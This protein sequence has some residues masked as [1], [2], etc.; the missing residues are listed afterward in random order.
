MAHSHQSPSPTR[1]HHRTL[2]SSRS[3]A[4]VSG[5][6]FGLLALAVT[7]MV[8]NVVL[9]RKL[10]Q[11]ETGGGVYSTGVRSTF[12]QVSTADDPSKM[13][14]QVTSLQKTIHDLQVE[15]EQ[16][17][18]SL[19]QYI[20]Q[21]FKEKEEHDNETRKRVALEKKFQRDNS[22]SEKEPEQDTANL[23]APKG[24]LAKKNDLAHSQ[25]N[26][27][28]RIRADAKVSSFAQALNHSTPL[29]DAIPLDYTTLPDPAG[30]SIKSSVDYHACCG[31]G[32]RLSRMSDANYVAQRLNLGLRSFWGFCGNLE[33]HYYL[34]GPQRENMLAN[35]TDTGNYLRISKSFGGML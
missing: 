31:L 29:P 35:V 13:A 21:L 6:K 24:E 15:N 7:A 16:M 9:I 12:F 28:R 5:R 27:R 1:R 18:Q 3:F 32:H 2:P 34:F 25:P 19:Q 22:P 26:A 23:V 14:A 8:C 20:Q 11:I 17:K 4:V 10:D 30:N 33:V